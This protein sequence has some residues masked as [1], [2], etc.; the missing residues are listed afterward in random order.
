MIGL[1]AAGGLLAGWSLA[2]LRSDDREAQVV[3]STQSEIQRMQ[4]INHQLMLIIEQRLPP[5]VAKTDAAVQAAQEAVSKAEGASKTAAGAGATAR[6][7]ATT[8]KSAANKA[9]E[10]VADVKEAV[11]PQPVEPKDPPDWLGGS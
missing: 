3:A 7:A 11:T 8:A 6:Q 2:K 5:L 10:A 4:D 9:S 1:V